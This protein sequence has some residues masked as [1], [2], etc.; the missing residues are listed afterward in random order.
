MVGYIETRTPRCARDKSNLLHQWC[1][2][3]ER[4]KQYVGTHH[5][6][7]NTILVFIWQIIFHFATQFSE[8]RKPKQNPVNKEFNVN[9]HAHKLFT[10][11][12]TP[13]SQQSQLFIFRLVVSSML[14]TIQGINICLHF[15]TLATLIIHAMSVQ[16]ADFVFLLLLLIYVIRVIE[17]RNEENKIS[18][19]TNEQL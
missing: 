17:V 19:P 10:S 6:T 18:I 5:R 1:V 3:C 14:G 15:I 9:I 11:Q 2:S 8:N 16:H 4:Q 13:A 12:T 7:N